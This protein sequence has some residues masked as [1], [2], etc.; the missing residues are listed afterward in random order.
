MYFG[1]QLLYWLAVSLYLAAALTSL[2]HGKNAG[3]TA[4]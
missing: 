1:F 2:A 3:V 4:P